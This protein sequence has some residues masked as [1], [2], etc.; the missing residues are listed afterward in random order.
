MSCLS[1]NCQGVG[2]P[3]KFQFLQ[4]T[5][6]QERPNVVFLCETLSSKERMEWVRSRL[7]FHGMI[8]VEAEGRSG[9][10]GL[11]WREDVDVNLLSLSINHIDVE[12]HITGNQPWRLTGFYGEPNRNLRS[13]TL[14]L[15]RTL[16]RDSNLPWCIIGDMNNIV[17]QNDKKG[18]AAYPQ[19]L[20]DGFNM[21]FRRDPGG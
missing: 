18:G 7:K 8:V 17:N 20:I 1:W 13:R 15:L 5:V 3:W 11:I 14:N 2:A 19:N 12:I 6:R 16:V 10:L 9:G 4:D 21:C